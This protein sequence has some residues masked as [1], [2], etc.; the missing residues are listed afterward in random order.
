MSGFDSCLY[1]GKF[2]RLKS[3]VNNLNVKPKRKGEYF[4]IALDTIDSLGFMNMSLSTLKKK[5]LKAGDFEVNEVVIG[6]CWEFLKKKKIY[7]F[8]PF[9]SIN[10][11]DKH[12]SDFKENGYY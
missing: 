7:V 8:E 2:L 12:V 10:D 5:T 9:E 4:S 11:R 6:G 3:Q 1:M